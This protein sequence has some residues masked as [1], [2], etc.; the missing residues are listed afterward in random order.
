VVVVKHF[1]RSSRYLYN[2]E[3][4]DLYEQTEKVCKKVRQ[5]SGWMFRSFYNRQGWFLRHMWNSLSQP[6]VDYC[7]QLWALDEGGEL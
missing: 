6:H 5:K 1:T 4:E 2:C 3:T 7:S